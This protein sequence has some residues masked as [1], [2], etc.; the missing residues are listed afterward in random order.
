MPDKIKEI[1]QKALAWWNKFTAKQKTI[2]IGIAAAV[3]FTFAILVYVFTKP[4]YM[5]WQQCATTSEAAEVIEI[6]DSNAIQYEVSSDGLSIRVKTSQVSAANLALGAAGYVP[7]DYSISDAISGGFS[8]TQAD[9]QKQWVYYLEQ[10]LE[11]DISTF[12]S[13]KDVAVNLHIPDQTGTLIATEEE[14]S[15][16][17]QLTLRDKFTAEQAT[18]VARAVATALGNSST[19][20]ITIVDTNA[21]L[22]FSGEEDYSTAGVANNMLELRAQAETMVGADVKKVLVGSKQFD[23]VEVACRLDI[24]FAEYQRTI[25]EYYANA[26]REEGMLSHQELYEDENS[27]GVGGIPG[28]DS[29]DEITIQ[30]EDGSNTD[31]SSSQSLT[32]YLPNELISVENLPPGVINF[33]DSSLSLTAITYKVIKEEDARNQGLLDGISWEEYKAA[34]DVYT[35]KEVDQDF[36]SVVANA[37]GIPVDSIAILAFEVPQFID[38]EGLAVKTTDVLSVVLI[39]VILAL[40]GF[41]VIRSMAAKKEVT[42]EEELSV[43]NLLQSTPETSVEDIELET[44]SDT[45]KMIEKFVDDNPEAAAN[46]LRNWLNEDWG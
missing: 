9:K 14:T 27:S 23:M 11:R 33:D 5:Q 1:L 7:D 46:L 12:E 4:Q 38:K 19:A 28:T 31:S 13:V 8:A 34:N 35:K 39:M 25:H 3:V 30:Y 45:R 2:I 21:N 16:W 10:K 42:Q 15:A 44:K 40:L 41:V 20:N 24:D 22:L 29:N 37:T 26:D 6:L 36:Y 43:E 17:I 18:T 32:D